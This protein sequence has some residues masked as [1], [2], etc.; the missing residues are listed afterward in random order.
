MIGSPELAGSVL[1]PVFFICSSQA[2]AGHVYGL[3]IRIIV[4]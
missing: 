1:L 2:E 4:I 3:Q